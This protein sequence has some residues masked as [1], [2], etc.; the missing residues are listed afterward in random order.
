MAS[1]PG[2]IPSRGL[3]PA[4]RGRSH[5]LSSDSCIRAV[6]SSVSGS[7]VLSAFFATRREFSPSLSSSLGVNSSSSL[8]S[9][10]S[11]RRSRSVKLFALEGSAV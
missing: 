7:M 9:V 6:A 3:R 5:A 1:S 8:R 11:R 2:K 10:S 4:I